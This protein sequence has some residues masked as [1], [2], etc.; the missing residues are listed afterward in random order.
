M[1]TFPE[2]N[3]SKLI[4]LAKSRLYPSHP[5]INIYIIVTVLYT[6]PMD[7]YEQ[8]EFVNGR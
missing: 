2:V 8:E 5:N 6:I 7:R 4:W 1:N 3:K